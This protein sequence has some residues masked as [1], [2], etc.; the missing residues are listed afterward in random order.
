MSILNELHNLLYE[1]QIGY[2]TNCKLVSAKEIYEIEDERG[3]VVDDTLLDDNLIAIWITH[4]PE[5]A[6][7]YNRDSDEEDEPITQDDIDEIKSV[8]LTGARHIES[9][10]DGDG[11]ELWVK[12]R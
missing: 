2:S 4:N 3:N 5:D 7:R 12:E 11:G 10:D 9:M 6:V 8:D 1:A